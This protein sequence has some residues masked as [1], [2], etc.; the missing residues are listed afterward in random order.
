MLFP[1]ARSA[2]TPRDW[3]FEDR[4]D[5]NFCHHECNIAQLLLEKD[6]KSV[7]WTS[8]LPYNDRVLHPGAQTERRGDA[9]PVRDSPGGQTSPAACPL[10]L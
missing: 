1:W 9:G 2:A 3:G 7:Q 5:R 10:S 6:E 4:C 8:G